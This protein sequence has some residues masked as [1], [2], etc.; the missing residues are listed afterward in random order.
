[1]NE[2]EK[3]Q[4]EKMMI[5]VMMII[6][7]ITLDFVLSNICTDTKHFHINYYSVLLFESLKKPYEVKTII[8]SIL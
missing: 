1:M 7:V 4:P 3:K 2:T 5:I 6:I 8:I